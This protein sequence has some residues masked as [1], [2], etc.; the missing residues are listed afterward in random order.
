MRAMRPRP[1]AIA[2]GRHPEAPPERA[3]EVRRL[4]VANQARHVAHRDRGLIREQLRRDR[5]APREQVLLEARVA[6]LRVGALQL[7]WRARH[8]A[9]D[10]RQRQ[11]PA[12]MARDDHARQQV[13]P[14][15]VCQGL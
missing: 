10:H 15:S 11:R 7:P 6:E 13:E 3:R 8:R 1:L 12:V 5:H 2:R 14:A 9:R 4:A